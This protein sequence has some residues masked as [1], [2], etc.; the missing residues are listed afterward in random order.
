[1]GWE[2][3]LGNPLFGVG[4]N[5]HLSA[6]TDNVV[7]VNVLG[8]YGNDNDNFL[9]TNPVH[10]SHII[11][12]AELGVVGGLLWFYGFFSFLINNLNSLIGLNKYH[13]GKKELQNHLISKLFAVGVIVSYF[14]YAF[15]GWATMH[16]FTFVFVFIALLLNEKYDHETNVSNDNPN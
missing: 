13:S 11:I 16:Y 1:L 7:L 5:S 9:L 12:L 8:F 4:L 3:F 6:I 2:T 14:L 15:T 10:N